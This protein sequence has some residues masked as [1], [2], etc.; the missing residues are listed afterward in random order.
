MVIS[1]KARLGHAS[2]FAQTGP[3]GPLRAALAICARFITA[4]CGVNARAT[5][6]K[7]P[8]HLARTLL[9]CVKPPRV[10]IVRFPYDYGVYIRRD[11][12]QPPMKRLDNSMYLFD[13]I[14]SAFCPVLQPCRW[15]GFIGL[16]QHDNL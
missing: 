7:A 1:Y 14:H 11:I 16:I 13:W 15:R 8:S 12:N 5:C 3:S 4:T 6:S 9:A 2:G 10:G